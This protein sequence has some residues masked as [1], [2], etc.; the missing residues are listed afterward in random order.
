MPP[1]TRTCNQHE[2]DNL[3]TV[4][5]PHGHRNGTR[6][7][8]DGVL[9]PARLFSS[10]T[11]KIQMAGYVERTLRTMAT[12][13][14]IVADI[15]VGRYSSEMREIRARAQSGGELAQTHLGRIE[16]GVAGTGSPALLS[17]G[18]G[19]G[20][21]QGLLIGRAFA[22]PGVS[23]IA[24]SRFGY[25]GTALPADGSPTAQAH[26]YAALLD[27][28][29]IDAAI[30]VGVSAGAPSA[31]ELALHHAER[32]RRLILVVPRA[33]SPDMPARPFS[34][35]SLLALRLILSSDLA[36]WTAMRLAGDRFIRRMG[37]PPDLLTR[38]SAAER[39]RAIAMMRSV[40]PVSR[41]RAG[42]RNDLLT[43][44]APLPLEQVA[45]PTL[46]ITSRD[47]LFD[48]LPAARFMA[49][50]MPHARLIAIDQGGHL[51]ID[52][53]NEVA[54]AIAAFLAEEPGNAGN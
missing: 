52:R 21:D 26:A 29:G 42:M 25:L 27:T 36:Y 46:I 16:Y 8:R 40:L 32:V 15:L 35:A 7:S 54:A 14:A 22:P 18:A 50:R 2:C 20:Y 12:L 48:T 9:P 10:R 43:T 49:A 51:F 4:L 53:K 5:E 41:R 23:V 33:Y 34:R 24:P 30:V 31:L 45:V 44:L 17:H 37:V 28:L 3:H 47:D 6:R 38:A 1:V 11:A 19:G 13:G 39:A